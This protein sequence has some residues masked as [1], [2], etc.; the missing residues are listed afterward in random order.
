VFKGQHE[1]IDFHSLHLYLLHIIIMHMGD[2]VVVR[3]GEFD[4]FFLKRL[5]SILGIVPLSLFLF[6]HLVFNS[7]AFSGAGS[8]D[9]FVH[10]MHGLPF[11]WVL[12]VFFI[13]V[14][15]LIHLLLGFVIIYRGSVN[16]TSYPYYRNWMYLFQR[17]TGVI[18]FIF[19]FYH[20]WTIRLHEHFAGKLVT[21]AGMQKY[22]EPMF[23]KIFYIVG[24][25]S[26]IFHVSNGIATACITWGITVNKRSQFVMSCFSWVMML[27]LGVWSIFILFI[28]S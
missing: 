22:F 13:A 24:I 26:V 8:F 1:T 14:P 17:I 27:V 21:Y 6:M 20:I 11:L 25:L 4:Y 28:Y 2:N 7:F 16:I 5:Q 9:R 18:A 15:L 3:R 23:I 10:W 12:E 19:V